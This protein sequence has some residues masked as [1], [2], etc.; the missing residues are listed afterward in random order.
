MI[1]IRGLSATWVHR[2]VR[3]PVVKP[4]WL[5]SCAIC[6]IKLDAATVIFSAVEAIHQFSMPAIAARISKEGTR[7]NHTQSQ[8]A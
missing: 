1:Q 2:F 8:V 5:T 4:L 3:I 6:G 7:R